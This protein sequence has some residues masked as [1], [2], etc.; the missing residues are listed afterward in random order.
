MR[1]KLAISLLVSAYVLSTALALAQIDVANI[2]DAPGSAGGQNCTYT[3]QSCTVNN[4]FC[5]EW[6]YDQYAGPACANSELVPT[7]SLD[8][9]SREL[10]MSWTQRRR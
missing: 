5:W 8:G 7:P 4:Y 10:D 2:D 1:L 9:Q 3:H 6:N